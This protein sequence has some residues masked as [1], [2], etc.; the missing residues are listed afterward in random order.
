MKELGPDLY[1]RVYEFLKTNRSG[2]GIPNEEMM[3][4][5]IKKMVSGDKRLMTI[6]FNLD[7]IVFME[8]LQ[9]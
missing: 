1:N 3:H 6:C 4:G 7:G 5:E 2:A 8:I 9:S